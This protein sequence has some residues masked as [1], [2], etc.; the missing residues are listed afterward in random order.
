MSEGEPQREAGAEPFLDT[1]VLVYLLSDDSARVRVAE[2]VL[3]AGGVVSVQV[4][5]EFASVA[6]R[7]A[8]L[9]PPEVR[10]LLSAVRRFCRVVP[11][12]VETHDLALAL[13]DRYGYA[14]Y[15]SAILAAALLAECPVVMTEDMQ[16]DQNVMDALVIRNPFLA[17]A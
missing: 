6:M 15:E 4:L 2:R 17:A 16:T 1:N 3:S 10:E 5:N 12:T 7:K 14:T 8:G 9:A 11:M 13:C